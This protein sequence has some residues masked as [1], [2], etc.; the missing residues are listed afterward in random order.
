MSA[1]YITN[2]DDCKYIN[3]RS[4]QM[5]TVLNLLV[6]NNAMKDTF[7]WILNGQMNEGVHSS[8]SHVGY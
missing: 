6:F 4:I 8:F 3:H 7:G 5:R 2:D 1:P